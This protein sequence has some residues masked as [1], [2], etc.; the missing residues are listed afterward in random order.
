MRKWQ[1]GS[2]DLQSYLFPLA[3]DLSPEKCEALLF[4]QK[5]I[6]KMG[7]EIEQMGP[8]WLVG[9]CGAWWFENWIVD[10]SKR[11]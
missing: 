9:S 8:G 6:Q 5:D 3:I 4:Y 1:G 2:I 11:N 7:I 10:A